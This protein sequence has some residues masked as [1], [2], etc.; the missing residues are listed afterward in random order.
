MSNDDEFLSHINLEQ[1]C[2]EAKQKEEEKRFV[3]VSSGEI[4][5]LC[6]TY[7]RQTQNIE[8]RTLL[9]FFK[10]RFIHILMYIQ[11]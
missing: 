1:I 10:V 8:R 11:N 4:D 5:E 7:S 9:I 6:A 3:E 2:E